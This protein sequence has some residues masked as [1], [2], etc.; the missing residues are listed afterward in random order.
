MSF[1]QRFDSNMH[2]WCF[3]A[4]VRRIDEPGEDAGAGGGQQ[5]LHG[6]LAL[7]P[8]TRH[9]HSLRR[10]GLHVHPLRGGAR[11]QQGRAAEA[12]LLQAPPHAEPV[13]RCRRVR[14]RLIERSRCCR[15]R[16][17]VTVLLCARS[18]QDLIRVGESSSCVCLFLRRVLAYVQIYTC[19]ALFVLPQNQS[20]MS[21]LLNA[22]D[23]RG[24]SAEQV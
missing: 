15:Q 13:P 7:L 5:R 14:H 12:L 18:V 21:K 20:C 4:C 1:I 24:L 6:P 8:R 17:S 19:G 9:R 10:L 22:A 3:Q 23:V 11:R 16:A 2:V